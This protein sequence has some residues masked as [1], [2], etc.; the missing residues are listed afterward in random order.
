MAK[1]AD[2][3]S[4]STVKLLFIGDP[5]SGK[6]GALASLAEAGYNLRIADMDNG[7]D[8]LRNLLADK[9]EALARVD[10]ET[11]TDSFKSI[12]GRIIPK[13][14][15]AWPKLSKVLYEWPGLGSPLTWTAQDVLVVDSMTLAGLAAL[16]YVL[17]NNVRLGLPPW[18]SD[19]GEAQNLIESMC[20]MLYDDSLH[21]NVIVTSHVTLIGPK[22][23]PTAEKGYATTIGKALSPKIGRYF[24]SILYVQSKRQGLNTIRE[25]VTQP[26]SN[27]ELKVSKP[28]VPRSYPHATGLAQFFKDLTGK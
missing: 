10:Y 13:K 17:A 9:P 28:S 21:C 23:N 2:H 24:N 12:N 5:G 4:A 25:I 7:V 19:Y 15:E 8:I 1:L 20:Q 3:Q 6:T 18:Q 14:A 26:V 11:C 16:R 27:I 22:D